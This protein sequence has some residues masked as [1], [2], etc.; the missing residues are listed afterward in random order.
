MNEFVVQYEEC[1]PGMMPTTVVVARVNSLSAALK[2]LE[3]TGKQAYIAH[4]PTDLQRR[5]HNGRVVWLDPHGHEVTDP[6]RRPR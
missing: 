5:I 6:K 3:Q 1:K 2:F 4:V